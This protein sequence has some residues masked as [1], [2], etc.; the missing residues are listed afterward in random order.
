[1]TAIEKESTLIAI[2]KEMKK[3]A[4]AFSGGVDS[5]YLIAIAQ[6]TLG[7]NAVAIT[8]KTEY[9][10][11]RDINESINL[12]ALIKIKHIVIKIN[13]LENKQIVA[14]TEQRCFFCK[15]EMYKHLIDAA[16]ECGINNYADGSNI[17]DLKED[18]PGLKA[19][20]NL[21][22]RSPLQEAGLSKDDIR[23][24]SKR[25]NL[26]T[27]NKSSYSCLATSIPF[28]NN[29][30]ITK[31]EQIE[32]AEDFLRTLGIKQ[33]RVRHHDTIARIEISHNNF[34][35]LILNQDLIIPFFIQLGFIYVTLDLR[36]YQT[37]S[38]D[39]VAQK[40]G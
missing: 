38:L 7:E 13:A 27:W 37:V 9:I 15:T 1:M 34:Y 17:D 35:Q 5:T 18:R 31:I 2:I 28:G 39:E 12:T 4:I 20:R 22:F 11:N 24:L 33:F 30:T 6:K 21:E 14:N 10:S 23:Y 8:L 19:L 29:L 32:K 25:L 16:K 3:V 40:E 36:G 26:P